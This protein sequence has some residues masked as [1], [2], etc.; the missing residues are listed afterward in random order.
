MFPSL[1]QCKSRCIDIPCTGTSAHLVPSDCAAW[2]RFSNDPL[3]KAWVEGNCGGSPNAHLDPC[4]CKFT[5]QTQCSSSG[6]ITHLIMGSRGLS[7]TG[8]PTALL[9]L[10]GLIYL[11]LWNSTLS[12]TRTTGLGRL[13]DL[14][15]LWLSDNQ[16][17]GMVPAEL[18]QLNQLKFLALDRNYGLRGTLPAFNFEQLTFCCALNG[19][20]FSCPLPNGA[21]NCNGGSACGTQTPPTCK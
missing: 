19:G 2:Q 3:Y 8:I 20:N 18:A 21:Q 7:G 5:E 16:F 14:S 12:G 17:T 9:N 11:G 4:S 6:R 13:T 1:A 15:E 10:T